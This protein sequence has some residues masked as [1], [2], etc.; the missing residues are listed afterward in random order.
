MTRGIKQTVYGVFYIAVFAGIITGF[1]FVFIKPAPSCFDNIQNQGELGV[2]CGGPC[3]K[4]CIPANIKPIT[5]IGN[6]LVFYEGQSKSNADFL[7]QV[8]NPNRDFAAKSFSYVFSLY[9]GQN[10][11]LQSYRGA[12]FLYA[13]DVRYIFMPNIA[14]PLGFSRLD[15]AV[16]D[17]DWVAAGDFIGPPALAIQGLQVNTAGG[18]LVASGNVVNNDTIPFAKVLLVAIFKGQ[19]GQIAGASQTEIDNLSV[20]EQRRFS[21]IRPAILNVDAAA[22][23]V[24][25]YALRQ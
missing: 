18:N 3:A 7:A 17:P 22:T 10:N 13:G 9:D 6:P 24:F 25:A 11:L 4:V 21:I 12:S 19:F 8:S 2:D 14:V 16:G 23:Q 1:Y 5:V 20:N 15:F